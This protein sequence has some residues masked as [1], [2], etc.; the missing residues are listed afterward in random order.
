MNVE[1]I[2]KLIET[3]SSPKLSKFDNNGIS[4]TLLPEGDYLY[5]CMKEVSVMLYIRC[6]TLGE[7]SVVNPEMFESLLSLNI[8]GGRYHNIRLTYDRDTT[9]L[10]LCYDVMLDTVTPETFQSSLKIFI[11]D[12]NS[13]RNFLNDK[14][15]DVVIGVNRASLKAPVLNKSTS[16]PATQSTLSSINTVP[17]V[18]SSPAKLQT[19]FD[20]PSTPVDNAATEILQGRSSIPETE[21]DGMI[22]V[23]VAQSM[24]MMA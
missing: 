19:V 17:P 5:M 8:F 16:T 3:V 2:N 9:V 7:K 4:S 10:W 20:E 6:E 14:I 21:E 22:S 12:A 15:L 23:M 11:E 13:F 24:F 18:Q 1:Q